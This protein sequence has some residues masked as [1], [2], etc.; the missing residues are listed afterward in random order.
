MS[1]TYNELYFPASMIIH[2]YE[3][4]HSGAKKVMKEQ[5]KVSVTAYSIGSNLIRIDIKEQSN[6]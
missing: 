2:A 3:E 5:D 4:V 6:D 1:L